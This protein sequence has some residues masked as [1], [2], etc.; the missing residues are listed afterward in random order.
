MSK[1]GS[2]AT[3]VT[4]GMPPDLVA[5]HILVSDELRYHLWVAVKMPLNNI[6][7]SME[8]LP[9]HH[10]G[11]LVHTRYQ[12]SLRHTK[13][14]IEYSYCPFCDRTTKDYGGK[15]HTYH[16]YGTL[17]S[18]V[19][20]D[21][22]VSLSG[23]LELVFERLQDLFGVSPYDKM[24]VL[25]FRASLDR[26]I[27]Q[28]ARWRDFTPL[29]M[30][31]NSCGESRLIH[32]DCL[33][34]LQD[35]PSNSVDFIFADPPYNLRK[36]YAGYNDSLEIADYFN[37]CD[38]W[39][40]E[41]ARLLKPGRTLAILNIP[42]W[43]IR[44][45]IFLKNVLEF[46]YWI[47]WDALSFPVRL[48]MPAH[49]AILCFSKGPPRSVLRE[50][51][52]SSFSNCEGVSWNDPLIPMQE[53]ACL[54]SDCITMRRRARMRDNGSLTDLWWD[55]HRLKHNSRRV[56]HPC[57]LPPQ[58]MFRLISIFSK[59]N[60]MVLDPFNGAGTT[61]L[62]AELL[63]RRYIGIENSL[64]YHELAASRHKELGCGLNP[65]RKEE[66][67]L[68]AKNS[69]VRR[70][71]KQKYEVSKKAL[72]MEIKRIAGVLGRLPKREEVAE[73]GKFPLRFY[74]EY[75]VSWGEVCAAARTTGMQ[76]R[77]GKPKTSTAVG[78]QDHPAQLTLI[79]K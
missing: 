46:Q 39:I 23:D 8:Q 71:P 12:S 76:E 27:V 45:F 14:R 57:Q 44:H 55:I 43:S 56:D 48:I 68:S 74:E 5:A 69:P 15:K 11:I 20:R 64:M 38:K 2:D 51:R 30:A 21:I 78:R 54:R 6:H 63:K 16:E 1:L 3:L 53:G 47:A 61:T 58:L 25:D 40:A 62:C 79:S 70:L 33:E 29:D 66:K 31:V 24:L 67:L 49:Y 72:Q 19:W 35:L 28:C 65:F 42:L 52:D 50:S 37:W 9:E 77:R 41:L 75:F 22:E 13:T 34:I 26:K 59:Q 60:E 36:K 32:G 73:M 7:L 17:L 18:D 4:I 10:F